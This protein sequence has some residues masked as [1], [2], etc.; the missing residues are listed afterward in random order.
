[1]AS[2]NIRKR[3]HV[4]H[5]AG[6]REP[7]EKQPGFRL[8]D[9]A[10]LPVPAVRKITIDL[11]HLLERHP[12]RASHTI[13]D[14]LPLRRRPEIFYDEDGIIVKRKR[15]IVEVAQIDVHTS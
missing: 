5:D 2:D 15:L 13:P 12:F 1:M 8:P 9:L 3:F 14:G 4:S 11:R 10:L 6:Q 7:L